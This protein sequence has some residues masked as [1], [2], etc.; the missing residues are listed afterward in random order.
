[1]DR[2]A[3][4]TL[5]AGAL[6]APKMLMA[7]TTLPGEQFFHCGSG[8]FGTLYWSKPR[9][10]VHVYVIGQDGTEIYG[11]HSEAEMRAHYLAQACDKDEAAD[12]LLNHL[13]E[14]HDLDTPID[15]LAEDENCELIPMR[16]TWREIAEDA[17]LPVQLSSGYN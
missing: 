2:R 7:S 10:E 11:A 16:I 4:L 3:F 9:Q 15:Y 12:D 5:T 1:M 6:A 13:Y 14:I 17:V 8:T